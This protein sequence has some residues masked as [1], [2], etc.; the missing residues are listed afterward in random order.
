MNFFKEPLL[1][2]TYNNNS[3][4]LSY[5]NNQII[6]LHPLVSELIAT[7]LKIRDIKRCKEIVLNNNEY[8]EQFEYYY[9][10]FLFLMTSGFL[11]S[12]ETSFIPIDKNIIKKSISETTNIVFEVTEKCN[13][14][15]KYCIYGDLYVKKQTNL[16]DKEL[17]IDVA[18]KI[19]GLVLNQT[20]AAPPQIFNI[21]FYG[22]EPLIRFSF[23]KE[24]VKYVK[25][26]WPKQT[27]RFGMTTNAVL[28]N[29]YIDFLIQNDFYIL[30]SLDGNEKHNIYRI[31]K[32]NSQSFRKVFE[33]ISLLKNKYPKYFENN[34]EFNS[35]IHSK[36]NT[37]DVKSFFL[38]EFNK[39]PQFTQELSFNG[40]DSK[41]TKEYKEILNSY[42]SKAKESPYYLRKKILQIHR[43]LNALLLK[44]K[45]NKKIYFINNYNATCLPFQV[46]LFVT[47]S[48]EVRNCEKIGTSPSLDS[49]TNYNVKF[50]YETI[51]EIFADFQNK[52]NEKCSECYS[53][54]CKDCTLI[55][56]NNK[57]EFNCKNFVSKN[58]IIQQLTKQISEIENNPIVLYK[59]PTVSNN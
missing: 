7:Y 11:E 20:L 5:K 36:S 41:K 18:K 42:T 16:K 33:N 26:H 54:D 2:K 9:N 21:S 39:V 53:I 13:L 19:I 14:K 23:I 34:V 29:K 24:I 49:F 57:G 27:F 44:E 4:L 37:E 45:L 28:L 51:T 55:H 10:K 3:Y 12:K 58:N 17:N 46:K 35:V 56:F 30:L 8:S 6:Y 52:A 38:K 48:G 15:C 59:E 40:L 31:F 50:N 32:N 43:D 47:A 22:G 1:F 25:E